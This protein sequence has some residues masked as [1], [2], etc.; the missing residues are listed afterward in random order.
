MRIGQ[1]GVQWRQ[2]D[3]GAIAKEQ[4]HECQV[5]QRRI[6]LRDALDQHR[7]HHGLQ[8]F[9]YHRLRRHID[10]NGAEKR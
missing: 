1:P 10:Q 9:A 3:L 5:E 7:P 4:E 8:P 2:A 6:E